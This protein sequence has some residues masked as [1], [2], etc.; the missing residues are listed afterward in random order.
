MPHMGMSVRIAALLAFLLAHSPS[1]GNAL[2][3]VLLISIDGLRP[4]AISASRTPAINLLV[5]RG[6][7]TMQARSLQPT[8]TIPNHVS[9]LTGKTPQTHGMLFPS[10]PGNAIV[11][12]SIIEMAH[13]AGLSSGIYISKEKLRLLNKP[14]TNDRYVVTE[15]GRAA[16]VV[17][18]LVEDLAKPDM[19]WQLTFLH[20]VDP[21]TEGHAYGWMSAPYLEAVRRADAHIATL[22]ESLAERG[23]ASNTVVCILADHGGFGTTHIEDRPEVTT[24]P[25]IAAGPGIRQDV[26]LTASVSTHDTA[27]TILRVLGLPIPQEMEGRLIDEA[28]LED[29]LSFLRGD[30]NVDHE[31]NI[32][33]ALMILQHL[34]QGAQVSCARAADVN[35]DSILGIT[36]AIYLLNHLFLGGVAPP[37]PF[38]DCSS[39][40]SVSELP[41]PVSC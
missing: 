19:Q 16:M 29:P 9:M 34:F 26:T 40:T 32:T 20:I 35:A 1:S 18:Q 13:A 14:G 7:A 24:I 31:V 12:D 6:V 37:A 23:L 38:P 10:D 4:D 41:C 3:R 36:Y 28:F 21:D 22:M 15:N 8:L 39:T 11:N 25:W 5:A 2:P 27:P 30:P 17:S 33:D